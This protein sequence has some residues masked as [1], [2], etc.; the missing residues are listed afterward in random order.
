M[1]NPEL[2]AI[3]KLYLGI[4]NKR[5]PMMMPLYPAFRSHEAVS[6]PDISGMFSSIKIASYD[7]FS[8]GATSLL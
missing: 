7:K 3:T 8:T 4:A 2:N 5:V 1:I 6:G